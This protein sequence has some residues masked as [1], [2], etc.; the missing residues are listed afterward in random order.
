MSTTPTVKGT[1]AACSRLL[2]QLIQ[3][4]KRFPQ[5]NYREYFGKLAAERKADLQKTDDLVRLKE[6]QAQAKLDLEQMRRMVA[7]SRLYVKNKSILET[8][9]SGCAGSGVKHQGLSSKKPKSNV[10]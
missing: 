4:T 8:T 1:K 2:N 10:K 9:D 5:L 6:V 7:T 3:E